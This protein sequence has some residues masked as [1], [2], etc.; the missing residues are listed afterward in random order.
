MANLDSALRALRA[1]ITTALES[2]A[3]APHGQVIIGWPVATELAKI[4]GQDA[5]GALVSIWPMAHSKRTTRYA[6]V[7]EVIAAPSPGTIAT[8]TNNQTVTI[9]GAP[10][11]GDTVH[12]FFA[13]T[14]ADAAHLVTATDTPATIA[15]ALATSANGF[16]LPGITASASGSVVT[17]AG[18]TFSRVN[19]GGVGTLGF[20]VQRILR[21]VMVTVWASS[22]NDNT[23]QGQDDREAIGEAILSAIG[24]SLNHWL[25][26]PDGFGIYVVYK[27]DRWSDEASDS[28][29]LF[30]WDM[31]F[32]LEYPV[33]VTTSAPQVESV[34]VSLGYNSL[35]P[36]TAYIGGP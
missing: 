14:L 7:A 36:S 28:Y 20:E 12:A 13:G 5:S 35:A 23:Q 17:L 18:S 26:T 34:R 32:D 9:S 2:S 24:T 25:S 1:S 8:L 11:P 22:P 29:T 21:T 4:M 19:V 30:R 27:N 31:F 10:K 16:A 15:A 3:V 6:P 33:T